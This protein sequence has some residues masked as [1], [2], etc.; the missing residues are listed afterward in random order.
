MTTTETTTICP[1]CNGRGEFPCF[2]QWSDGL[3]GSSAACSVCD[4]R[5][6]IDFDPVKQLAEIKAA[7]KDL[8]Y[9]T[10]LVAGC[11]TVKYQ[12]YEADQKQT[13]IPCQRHTQQLRNNVLLGIKS[14]PADLHPTRPEEMAKIS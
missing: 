2:V 7:L 1:H 12:D 6:T 14:L 10:W 8:L 13:A 3:G 4:G 5:G 11:R 9:K